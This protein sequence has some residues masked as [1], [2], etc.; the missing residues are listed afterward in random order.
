MRLNSTLIILIFLSCSLFSFSQLSIDVYSGYNHSQKIDTL[1][2]FYD[3]YYNVSYCTGNIL[4]TM[5]TEPDTMLLFEFA[6]VKGDYG[7]TKYKFTPKKVFGINIQYAYAKFF[8]TG[9]S[10]EKHGI[11]N[12]E[13]S[14]V[15][16]HY[17]KLY[18]NETMT[19][20]SIIQAYSGN[21]NLDY[22]IFNLSLLQS[23]IYPHK[24]LIF[25]ADFSL[26]FNYFTLNHTRYF[27][28]FIKCNYYTNYHPSASTISDL[29]LKYNGKSR[30]YSVGIGISYEFF[31]NISAFGKV[32]YTWANLEF[33]NWQQTYKYYYHSDDTGYLRTY[34]ES[35]PKELNSEDIPFEKINYNSWNF[36]VGLRYTFNK[37]KKK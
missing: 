19:S 15:V 33:Q 32:G 29:E 18:S 26:N 20:D 27:N 37:T 9:I 17:A 36:R 11:L 23:F 34:T 24:N 22:S 5:S 16:E 28:S 10:F 21:I 35:D 8:K 3:Y 7:Q 30:G 4:D 1:P 25:S 6:T 13:S 12:S 2:K 14:F 31:T